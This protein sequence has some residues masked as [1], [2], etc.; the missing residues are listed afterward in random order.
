MN[1]SWND[2]RKHMEKVH[3]I[4]RPVFYNYRY[5][6]VTFFMNVTVDGGWGNSP[7]TGYKSHFF[8][9]ESAEFYRTTEE[10]EQVARVLNEKLRLVSNRQN[11]NTGIIIPSF[12]NVLRVPKEY[13]QRLVYDFEFTNAQEAWKVCMQMNQ[14]LEENFFTIIPYEWDAEA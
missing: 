4:T 3:D 1:R 2:L 6:V 12:L 8:R 13:P 11:H 14:Q 5:Q 7:H 10:A 9:I